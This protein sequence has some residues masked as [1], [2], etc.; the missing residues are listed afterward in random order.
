MLNPGSR[1]N[2]SLISGAAGAMALTAV[3]QA[4]RAL[5]DSAPRMDVVGMRALARGAEAAGTSAPRTHDGRYRAT[6]AGD[7]LCNSAYYSLATT[8]T[9][10]A[11][12]GLLAGIGALVLPQKMGLGT[13]PKSELLSNRAMTVAWYLIG[14]LA[15]A[16]TAQW[17]A[18]RRDHAT[19]SFV[20]SS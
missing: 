16:C 13:P 10:G 4:A 14:G 6:L 5:T 1:L 19:Q 2:D 18:E 7:L 3:H 8:Y 12:L 11:A 9:R 17:L 15:A 20:S